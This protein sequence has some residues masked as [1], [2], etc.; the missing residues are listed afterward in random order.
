LTNETAQIN[1]LVHAKKLQDP[2]YKE[3]KLIE[4]APETP[5]G[6]FNYFVERKAIYKRAYDLAIEKFC[7][8][9]G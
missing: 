3:V 2:D 8:P 7:G 4:I 5:A 6:F 1:G 9:G